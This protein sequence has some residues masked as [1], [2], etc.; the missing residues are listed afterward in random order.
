MSELRSIVRVARSLLDELGPAG[1]AVIAERARE[2]QQA[3]DAE[4]AAFWAQVAH[5]M[6]SLTDGGDAPTGT[7]APAKAAPLPEGAFFDTFDQAPHAY[8]LLRPDLTI[9]GANRA[10]A[11]ATM[12]QPQDILDRGIFDVFPDNPDWDGADGEKNLGKSLAHV[13]ATLQPDR[14]ARQRYD[15][16]DRDGAF[17][18]RWWEPL[19]APILDGQG[20]LALILH[21]VREATDDAA[22]LAA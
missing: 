21:H 20:R 7:T 22:P 14:M 15:V 10:Y 3:G 18:E 6:R 16:R 19:N 11:L 17:E 2:H 8:L 9:A 13:V 4:A 12:T 5:A 1:P